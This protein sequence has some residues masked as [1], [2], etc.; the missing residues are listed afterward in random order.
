M[1]N[2]CD[3]IVL[4]NLMCSISSFFFQQSCIFAI[5]A[6]ILNHC[7]ASGA[8]IVNG[9]GNP[10]MALFSGPKIP[11]LSFENALFEYIN[12]PT[13]THYDLENKSQEFNHAI[14]NEHISVLL[15]TSE[16]QMK[17]PLYPKRVT[18]AMMQLALIV[19][20]GMLNDFGNMKKDPISC[21]DFLVSILIR[22][23]ERI[24]NIRGILLA[25]SKII[26]PDNENGRG[27]LEETFRLF[28]EIVYFHDQWIYLL[29]NMLS[30]IKK[31]ANVYLEEPLKVKMEYALLLPYVIPV[32]NEFIIIRRQVIEMIPQN[33]ETNVADSIRQ[34]VET[35]LDPQSSLKKESFLKFLLQFEGL[36]EELKIP[37]DQIKLYL[38]DSTIAVVPNIFLQISQ[39]ILTVL[40]KRVDFIIE[41][42]HQFAN[43]RMELLEQHFIPN[44]YAHLGATE[45]LFKENCKSAFNIFPTKHPLMCKLGSSLR[46]INNVLVEEMSKVESKM[47]EI[48]KT[49][50][51][52]NEMGLEWILQK[53]E[54]VVA[55]PLNK[56]SS[57]LLDK[58]CCVQ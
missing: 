23:K 47:H 27:P 58:R 18:D 54:T 10:Y 51:S 32:E 8:F 44:A 21:H 4:S 15:G 25:F 13:L 1:I 31:E 45:K 46:T 3:L 57:G 43:Q 39:Q 34:I 5:F 2:A 50:P 33:H 16:K 40:T 36:L 11:V 17:G 12:L 28:P 53:L 37:K 41:H 19:D 35:T 52:S 7:L 9:S 29:L 22:I 56:S 30:T 20:A 55:P 14:F 24:W 48:E 49:I 6:G 38:P 42:S 26:K